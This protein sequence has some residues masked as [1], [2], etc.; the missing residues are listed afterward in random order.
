MLLALIYA[1]K[2]RLSAPDERAELR[3]CQ[4]NVSALTRVVEALASANAGMARSLGLLVGDRPAGH[5]KKRTSPLRD[6]S[7][8][9]LGGK[10]RSDFPDK[11]YEWQERAPCLESEFT[12]NGG[13]YIAVGTAPCTPAAFEHAGK[14]YVAIR[15][16]D[17]P[18][19]SE[20]R[21]AEQR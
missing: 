15:K 19:R 2:Y 21:E 16:K 10:N 9:E 17:P 7:S 20:G 18:P 11:P 3:Q 8:A 6:E 5:E 14:C 12:M 1:W 4:E 13:C